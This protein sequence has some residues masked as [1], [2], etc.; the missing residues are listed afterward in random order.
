ME[1]ARRRR[2]GV[3]HSWNAQQAKYFTEIRDKN[4]NMTQSMK[5]N[6]KQYS[7]AAG[8]G[9]STDEHCVLGRRQ[10]LNAGKVVASRQRGVHLRLRGGAREVALE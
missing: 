7:I 10:T 6:Y 5:T 4:K 1:G 3:E 8:R 2:G 9:A